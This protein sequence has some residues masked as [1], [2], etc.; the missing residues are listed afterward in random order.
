MV[1]SERSTLEFRARVLLIQVVD[2]TAVFKYACIFMMTGRRHPIILPKSFPVTF[3]IIVDFH[4][5]NIPTGPQLLFDQY[6]G[7][8][9][10]ENAD[11]GIAQTSGTYPMLPEQSAV[12]KAHYGGFPE[13]KS[14]RLSALWSHCRVFL[15]V[16]FFKSQKLAIT[17]LLNVMHVELIKDLS[18]T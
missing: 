1:P 16:I 15:R 18:T 10:E 9:K 14:Q 12:A 7:Q 3:A 5:R 8:R 17:L 13:E 2:S 4:E 6:I 11:E